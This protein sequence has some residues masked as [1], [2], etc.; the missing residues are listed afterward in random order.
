VGRFSE[1]SLV[2]VSAGLIATVATVLGIAFAGGTTSSQAVTS[3]T[4]TPTADA[5]VRV[6]HPDS[7]Y[8]RQRSSIRVDGDPVS[9]AYL[10]FDLTGSGP[11]TNATLKLFALSPAV[12]AGIDVRTVADNG[13]SEN[14][15]TYA[16][17]PTVGDKVAETGEFAEG[18]WVSV[19]VSSAV[20][21]DGEVTLALTTTSAVSRRIATR[22]S[23]TPAQLSVGLEPA[24]SPPPPPPPPSGGGGEPKFPIRAA[25]YYPWF[26]EAW[27]QQGTEPFTKYNPS[28]G[29]YRSDDSA[30]IQKHVRAMEYG[31]IDAGISSWWGQGS[32]EDLRFPKLLSE[33]EGLE[34]NLRWAP[35]YE[36]E[37]L[38]NPSA[39][40]IAGDL[41]YLKSHYGSQPAYLR[42]QG[43]PV[44]FVYADG[45]DGCGMADRWKQGNQSQSFYLVLKVFSGYKSCA[46][47]PDGWHQYAPAGAA[48]RQAGNSFAI[49]PGFNKA[50]ESSARLGRDID[51]FRRNVSDMVASKEPWQLVTTFNEWGEGT[52][53]E[54]AKEW[55]SSSGQGAY[56]DALHDNG[57]PATSPPPG[58]GPN[59]PPPPPPPP[60]GGSDP[61]VAAAGDISCAQAQDGS[62]SCQ[63]QATSALLVNQGLS[64]VLTL[65]DI[66]YE[67]GAIS[68]YNSYYDQTWG[69]VKS[70]TS[71]AP[72]NHDPYSSGY[73]AYFGQLSPARYYSFDVGDWHLISL[74]SNSVD[75]TQ[76][77]WLRSD[78]AAN[79]AKKCTLAYWHHPRFSSGGTHGNQT[80][81]APFWA[82][83]YAADADVVLSAHDHIYERFAPQTPSGAADSSRGIREFIVGTGGKS[84]YGV[85]SVKANSEVRNVDTFGV[86]QL[87]LGASDYKWSFKPIAGGSFT[88]SGTGSCH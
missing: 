5:N 9:T 51:R 30:V 52:S 58:P 6:D 35:Y 67:D 36:E 3:T 76:V 47:Q 12:G 25:F 26:P 23:S 81:V 40:K 21:G 85:G 73:S 77:N 45:G 86:L 13:W 71:P 31:G 2:M 42:I 19:D 87:T 10:R 27:N 54:S 20:K 82:E 28:L 1:S 33:T 32:K 79:K 4:F 14:T 22:D 11:V 17:A 49:S 29:F 65:G 55:E 53:V 84:H 68:A 66:Q 39:S 48:D 57:G 72:G 64:R 74:D 8:G 75:S 63:D 34:S 41:A 80:Q 60:G 44:I 78:L 37:S 16:N 15:I 62:S 83:L 59:P 24:P 88:D 56:L 61:V 69:R 46:S 50:G 38:G 70:I 43:R 18:E 7:K